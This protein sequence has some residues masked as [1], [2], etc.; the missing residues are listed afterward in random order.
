MKRYPEGVDQ[1]FFFEKRCPAHRPSWVKTAQISRRGAEG[2]MTVCLVDDLATLMW[3]QNLASLELHVPL[4]RAASPETPDSMVF[5]L[6]PGDG[7]G[8]PECARVA[9]ILRELLARVGLAGFA[10]T[11]GKKGLHVYVPLNRKET[12]F[13][14]DQ[15][16]LARR[17]RGAA[18]GSPGSRDREDGQGEPRRQGLH[19][20][21][22]ERRLDDDGLRLLPAG[23]GAADGFLSPLLGRGGGRGPAPRGRRAAHHRIRGAEPDREEGGPLSGGAPQEAEASVTSLTAC[24]EGPAPMTSGRLKAYAAKRRF[25]KTPEPPPGRRISREQHRVFVVQKHQARALHYDL[26][27]ELEGVLKSWAVPKGPSLD[28]SV[29][30]LAV[31]VEDHPLDYQDFEGNIPKGSYGA[32]SVIVWDKGLYHHPS[33]EEGEDDGKRLR[34]GLNKGDLKFVLHGEKLRGEFALVKTGEGRQV[35]APDQEAAIA[36]RR[37][38][39]S[40]RRIDPSLPAGRWRRSPRPRAG[41]PCRTRRSIASGCG[42]RWKTRTCGMRRSRRCRGACGRCSRRRPRSRSTTRTGSSK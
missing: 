38:R 21:V 14:D 1:D 22:A 29:K 12:T 36:T 27:L 26:R 16:L 31:M 9:L 18:E 35:L 4:A 42:R 15:G 7:A 17:R 28:P 30:R 11:S 41:L 8:I 19:Q 5:D 37:R 23:R 10:K 34:E 24:A 32:G 40:S 25:E 2:P 33:V 13:E 39:T 3:V 20:L 6:D